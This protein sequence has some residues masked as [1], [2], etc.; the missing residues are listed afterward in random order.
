MTAPCQIFVE[1][2]PVEFA[3]GM[4]LDIV[5]G[6]QPGI[7]RFLVTD[8]APWKALKNPVS[9]KFIT[10]GPGG[11]ADVLTL[12]KW[13]IVS[14]EAHA[15]KMYEITILDCRWALLQ[16]SFQGGWNIEQVDGARR[17]RTQTSVPTQ[18]T[19]V[20][21]AKEALMKLGADE[22][23]IDVPAEL[24]AIVL[25][26]NMGDSEG[27]GYVAGTLQ[28]V[29]I[30]LE[31]CRCDL[32]PTA[33][34][35]IAFTD[36]STDKTSGILKTPNIAGAVGELDIHWTLP[37]FI[38][39]TFEQRIERRFEIEQGGRG[40]VAPG[41]LEHEMVVINV[42]PDFDVDEV[43]RRRED[44]EEIIEWTELP[45]FTTVRMGVDYYD[46]LLRDFHK[47]TGIPDL[48]GALIDERTA[49]LRYEWIARDALFTTWKV[50][51]SKTGIGRIYMSVRLGRLGPKGLTNPGGAVFADFHEYS[52]LRYADAPGGL[53]ALHEH[54]RVFKFD[55]TRP[56][57]F[58]A[59]WISDGREALVFKLEPARTAAG[60]TLYIGLPNTAL[61]VGDPS[62]VANG[63]PC[64][65]GEQVQMKPNLRA[66]VYWNGLLATDVGNT[67]RLYEIKTLAFENGAVEET[68]IH[69]RNTIA[70]WGYDASTGAFPGKLLNETDL[71]DRAAYM[72]KQIAR[73]YKGGK[74][75]VGISSGIRHLKR[76]WPAG[77]IYS[78]SIRVGGGAPWEIVTRFDVIPEV[79]GPIV[80][81]R[82]DL[83]GMKP[84]MIG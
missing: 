5:R 39:T 56:A 6:S 2:L 16:K 22:P 7:F 12:Q 40:Y 43:N 19:C 82:K 70:F 49:R 25:P 35:G 13:Y 55:S 33:D 26:K 78:A 46:G 58:D 15:S 29:E 51:L 84:D 64:W 73:T 59:R 48:G 60:R 57:P 65:T 71:K 63:L 23:H 24:A 31:L 3:V 32:L 30:F 77:N 61:S 74:G 41:S 79:R 45:T 72:A 66:H 37:R 17:G 14:C 8:P 62:D 44:G 54:S 50:D 38:T 69:S 28:T 1:N 83:D 4:Q 68:R 76:F 75:G 10:P 34:G 42:A 36:R 20:Q 67:K 80:E 53:P 9:I 47:P 81:S 27:G 52:S 18:T 21:A 11:E